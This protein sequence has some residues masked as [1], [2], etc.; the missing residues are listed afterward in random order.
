MTNPRTGLIPSRGDAVQ[1]DV[2]REPYIDSSG[3]G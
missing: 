3:I 2:G 1:I